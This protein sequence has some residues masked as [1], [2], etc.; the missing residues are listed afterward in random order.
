MTVVLT[1]H[2]LS[3]DESPLC[4]SPELFSEHLDVISQ[5]RVDVLTPRELTEALRQGDVPARAVVVTFDDALAAAVREARPRLAAAGIRAAFYCVAGHLGGKSDWPS[6]KSDSPV[7]PLATAEDLRALAV[8]GHE[9]GSHG[10]SHAP[11]HGGADLPREI[12]ESHAALA[13]ATGAD[14]RTFAYPY[15]ASPSAAARTLVEQSYDGA[16]GTS[17][18]R[19]G[20]DS[21]RWNL[22]RVD[23]HYLRDPR[24]LRRVVTGSLDAYL[25]SRRI[26]SRARRALRKDYVSV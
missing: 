19:V 21:Q 22:P 24:L 4:V 10:W 13:A 14:V 18:G 3:A 9:I 1:Y 26:G 5:V 7:R 20:R 2:E 23:A 8:E 11:L 15:G 16:F 17:I 6:R 25:V 12:V